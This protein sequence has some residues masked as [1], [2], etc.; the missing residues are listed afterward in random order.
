M[1]DQERSSL[2]R[3]EALFEEWRVALEA[4]SASERRLWT[5][6]FNPKDSHECGRLGAETVRLRGIARDAYACLISMLE[7]EG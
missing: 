5:E 4:L 1:T 2:L 3:F 6:T 7:Q